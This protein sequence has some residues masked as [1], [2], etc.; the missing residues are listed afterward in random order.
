MPVYIHNATRP[1]RH[2]QSG[3]KSAQNA[4]QVCLFGVWSWTIFPVANCGIKTPKTEILVPW[5]GLSSVNVF[6]RS[7]QPRSYIAECLRLFHVVAECPWDW[8]CSLLVRFSCDFRL[9]SWDHKFTQIL[10]YGKCLHIY[11]VLLHGASDLDQRR[12]KTL[13]SEQRVYFGCEQCS[14]N[15]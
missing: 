15:F 5:I 8:D 10:P 3:P 7:L 14:P 1:I 11:T 2:V 12:I 4:S 9:G 6:V 13:H